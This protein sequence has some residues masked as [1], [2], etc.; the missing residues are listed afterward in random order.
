MSE[1]DKDSL[2]LLRLADEGDDPSDAD[3]ERI[4]K[5][6]VAQIAG[7][8]ATGVILTS[9]GTAKTSIGAGVAATSGAAATATTAVASGAAAGGAVAG[10]ASIGITAKIVGVVVLTTAA[11]GTGGIIVAKR[12]APAKVVIEERRRATESVPI[13]EP[14]RVALG[15]TTPQEAPALPENAELPPQIV[16]LPTEAPR[17]AKTEKAKATPQALP[18][19]QPSAAKNA[20]PSTE[21]VTEVEEIPA[22]GLQ[23]EVA[24][25]RAANK[26][27][28]KG[29]IAG[30][31]GLLSTWEREFSRMTS[32]LAEEALAERIFIR[33]AKRS[34]HE[35][36]LTENDLKW[37]AEHYP[38]SPLLPKIQRACEGWL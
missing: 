17:V 30:A 29:D 4:R 18:A 25:L 19:V 32:A 2:E 16:E 36:K 27:R 33:C 20:E 11:L 34:A 28:L 10:A 9:A 22:S 35:A 12:E 26:A 23:R 5:R 6:L 31:E 38:S 37:F 24:L 15:P 13:T 7:V 3:R 21:S 8:A 14:K 1:L